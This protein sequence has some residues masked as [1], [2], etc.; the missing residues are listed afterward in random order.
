MT[1]RWM[2]V[3][4]YE[5]RYEVSD[6]GRVRS[7][8]LVGGG[9]NRP[10]PTPM[11]LRQHERGGYPSVCLSI[12]GQSK[13]CATHL[14]V[15]AAFIGP[16]PPG[17]VARHLDGDRCNPA[18]A[19]LAYGTQAENEADKI[20]HGTRRFGEAASGV[21]LTEDRV[22]DILRLY[23]PGS[24]SNGAPAL[25]RLYGVHAATVQHIVAGRS[26]RH[27][28]RADFPNLRLPPERPPRRSRRGVAGVC[29]LCGTPFVSRSHRPNPKA[30]SRACANALI[31]RNNRW[32][33]RVPEEL[34]CGPLFGPGGE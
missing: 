23:R 30:C 3:S 26:W 22:R 8:R 5:G 7:L 15:A 19:N 6:L 16:R 34:R 9:V 21:R 11:L 4:G 33:A 32:K 31:S 18:L 20:A 29:H 27:I 2:P 12:G 14:L 28:D 13:S 24:T 10:R 1:E 25:A 17:M